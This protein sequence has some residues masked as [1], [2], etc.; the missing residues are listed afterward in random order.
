MFET[1][2]MLR[3][4]VG[5]MTVPPNKI[6]RCDGR[7]Q[8]SRQGAVPCDKMGMKICVFLEPVESFT[9]NFLEHVAVLLEYLKSN[10]SRAPFILPKRKVIANDFKIT[11][12]L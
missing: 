3:Q 6:G 12:I 7:G 8:D 9:L 5:Y 10:L 1:S 2:L 11:S 4:H